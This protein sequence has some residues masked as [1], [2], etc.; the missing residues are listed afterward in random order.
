VTAVEI[1]GLEELRRRFEAA[2]ARAPFRQVLREETEAIA[3]E[4]RRQAPSGLGRAIEVEDMSQGEAIAF[5]IGTPPAVPPSSAR[6]KGPQPPGFGRFSGRIYQELRTSF[7]TSR[8]GRSS[9]V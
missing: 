4:A 2:S 9:R 7:E 8:K 3:A 6:S 1:T 5:A